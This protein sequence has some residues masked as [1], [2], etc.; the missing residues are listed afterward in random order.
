MDSLYAACLAR[1]GLCVEEAAKLHNISRTAV[2]AWRSGTVEP[3]LTAWEDLRDF[4]AIIAEWTE[5][6]R[7]EWAADGEPLEVQVKQLKGAAL[8]GVAEFILS[9]P[10]WV[11]PRV[12]TH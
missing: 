2:E 5:L 3:P 6:S 1:L 10:V 11:S 7:E 9:A 8:M 4:N 12:R